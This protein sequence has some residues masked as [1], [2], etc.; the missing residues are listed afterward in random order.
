[1]A[2]AD[3][4][5][6]ADVRWAS[7]LLADEL[8]ALHARHVRRN[9][10]G[11][12]LVVKVRVAQ[13]APDAEEIPPLQAA[14]RGWAG[15]IS[16]QVAGRQPAAFRFSGTSD[17]EPEPSD[18][19]APGQAGRWTLQ[20]ATNPPRQGKERIGDHKAAASTAAIP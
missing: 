6:R 8:A 11:D 2:D 7:Q 14:W 4:I 12:R 1:M 5:K 9:N 15:S 17:A 20:T 3:D 10:A 19:L 16:L 13:S 18:C